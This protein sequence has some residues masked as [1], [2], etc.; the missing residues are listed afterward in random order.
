M[1]C[2]M[3]PD[4]RMFETPHF[5]PEGVTK[6]IRLTVKKY[7]Y[8]FFFGGGGVGWENHMTINANWS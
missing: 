6:T 1:N 7:I 2:V 3:V 5:I 4:P 8:F